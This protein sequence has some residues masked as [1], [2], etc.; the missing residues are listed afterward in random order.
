MGQAVAHLAAAAGDEVQSHLVFRGVSKTFPDGTEALQAVSFDVPRRQ[1]CVVLGPSG[2]GKSTLLRC[3]NGLTSITGGE[4]A[5]GGE[6]LARRSEYRIR[7]KVAM[8][9]QLFNLVER[10]SVAE[11]TLQGAVAQVPAWRV[12]L[13]WYPADLRARACE[14]LEGV[15]LSPQHLTRRVRELSGGQQQRVGIARALLLSPEVVLA[16]EPVASLDPSISRDVL[17]LLRKGADAQGATVM[18]SLH[19]PDLAREFGDRIVGMRAGKVVFDGP[20]EAFDADAEALIYDGTV[21]PSSP[22]Q[23]V[24]R[25]PVMEVAQ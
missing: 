20:P 12:A 24:S 7:R 10:A 11:N 25:A 3:V 21:T 17:A 8:V 22:A 13:G 19:Q 23:P 18:C 6:V 14:V 2:S 4:I 9:H 5:V 16:D 1:F 15:G